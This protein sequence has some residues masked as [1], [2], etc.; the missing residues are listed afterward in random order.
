MADLKKI[1]NFLRKTAN[2][3]W[4]PGAKDIANAKDLLA[5]KKVS[6]MLNPQSSA[7]RKVL[8]KCPLT[9]HRIQAMDAAAKEL[10][11]RAAKAEI[12][13][14]LKNL[15]GRTA[16]VGAGIGSLGVVGMTLKAIDPKLIDNDL[17]YVLKCDKVIKQFKKKDDAQKYA[18]VHQGS[19]NKGSTLKQKVG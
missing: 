7:L 16:V 18:A 3:A 9:R 15:I 5:A 1:G 2:K 10:G 19:V 6:E 14:N 17:F 8:D 13:G 4:N 12:K 11:N